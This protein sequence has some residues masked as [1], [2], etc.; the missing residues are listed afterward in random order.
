MEYYV[1]L[2]TVIQN[3]FS[4]SEYCEGFIEV[5]NTVEERIE[6]ESRLKVYEEMLANMNVE[7]QRLQ[8]TEDSLATNVETLQ[9]EMKETEKEISQFEADVNE[10]KSKLTIA[11]KIKSAL[12][13]QRQDWNDQMSVLKTEMDNLEERETISVSAGIYLSELQQSYRGPGLSV[14]QEAINSSANF[15]ALERIFDP[16]NIDN[17]LAGW[18][19][20]GWKQTLCKKT[21]VLNCN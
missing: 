17:I 6:L 14:I 8:E 10:R 2:H 9:N 21:L 11:Q 7:V 13:L 5:I 3:T 19:L 18:D 15:S 20:P 16:S 1:L 12:E 4:V